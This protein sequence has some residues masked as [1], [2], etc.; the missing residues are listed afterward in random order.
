MQLLIHGCQDLLSR[1]SRLHGTADKI[2]HQLHVFAAAGIF[3]IFGP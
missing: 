3:V 1:I 2:S